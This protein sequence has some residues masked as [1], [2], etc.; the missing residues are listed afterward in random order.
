MSQFDFSPESSETQK[1]DLSVVLK[2]LKQEADD[3]VAIISSIIQYGLSDILAE[4]EESLIKVWE[5][6]PSG[7]KHKV[8]LSLTHASEANFELIYRFVG[9]LGVKDESALVRAAAID[10]LWEE[11][12]VEIMTLFLECLRTDPSISVKARALSGLGKFILLG[13][14]GEIT[15]SIALEAQQLAFQLHKDIQQPIEVRRRALEA[16]SNSSNPQK[17]KL[18]RDAYHNDNHLMKVSS[19]FAMGRTCDDKWQ[20]I[21]LEELQGSDHELVYEA[22]RAC[23]EIQIEESV[24]HLKYY[25]ISE[26][27]EIQMMSIWALGEIGGKYAMELLSALEEQTD[28][29]ELLEIIS[30]AIDVASFSFTGSSF[31]FD[32]DD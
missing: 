8:I 29:E 9:M 17:D 32:I 19:L 23:G 28:D 4:D 24:E 18:I 10:L 15:Q 11:E 30:E 31:S 1:P 5:Q 21:L 2:T 12:S 26:D 3:D 16:L 7:Y 27:R 14:Y 25:I 6:L 13:E 20:D 22:I